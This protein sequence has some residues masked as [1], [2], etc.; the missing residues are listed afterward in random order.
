M[1]EKVNPICST[2]DQRRVDNTNFV[3][4][5]DKKPGLGEEERNGHV[6][7]PYHPHNLDLF[8]YLY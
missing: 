1:N 4:V 6:L 5:L 2:L 7:L 3:R 8:N